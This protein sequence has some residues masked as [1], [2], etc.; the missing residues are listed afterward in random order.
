MASALVV[1]GAWA[2]RVV[3]MVGW[4]GMGMGDEV[5]P[6]PWGIGTAQGWGMGVGW[7]RGGP[8][9]PRG[10]SMRVVAGL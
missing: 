6:P 10:L 9:G 1:G 4:G 3:L 2:L 8:R 5:R 7:P